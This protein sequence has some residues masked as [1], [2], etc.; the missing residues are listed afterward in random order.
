MKIRNSN[1]ARK[2]VGAEVHLNISA[3]EYQREWSLD[4]KTAKPKLKCVQPEWIVKQ[5][6]PD[7]FIKN[8]PIIQKH[9]E[10]RSK[11]EE[12]HSR[13]K[14]VTQRTRADFFFHVYCENGDLVKSAY[15]ISG[16]T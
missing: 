16:I 9:T 1:K 11:S 3:A 14:Q 10:F 13:M 15:H 7:F 5:I 2:P 4:I 8:V 12:I 6:L